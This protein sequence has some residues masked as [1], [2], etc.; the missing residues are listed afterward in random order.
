M[1]Q[2]PTLTETIGLDS[3]ALRG[4]AAVLWVKDP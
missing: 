1:R 4:T 2:I 3:S